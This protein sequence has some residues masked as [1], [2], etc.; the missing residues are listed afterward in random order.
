VDAAV[1]DW[2]FQGDP[3]IR[4][5]V[6]RDLLDAHP[7]E[8]E[9]ERERV[10]TE[11][12]GAQFLALQAPSGRWGSTVYG[13]WTGAFYTM[14]VLRDLGL[15]AGHPGPARAARVILDEGFRPTDGGLWFG[16]GAGHSE[17]C[18][19]GM[20]MAILAL[21][22]EDD[23][24]MQSLYDYLLAEQM[25]DGGWNCQR[26]NGATH[27][28]FHTTI[29][30]L[31]GLL[32]W[33]NRDGDERGKEAAARGTEFLLAHRLFRSHR[34][35]EVV[36][37]DFT[38]FHFPPRW[39]FDVLRGLD[40]MRAAACAPDE[41]AGEAIEL[42]RSRR[43]RDG[44]WQLASGYPGNEAVVMERAGEASRWNTLRALRVLRWWDDG[45]NRDIGAREPLK[46]QVAE[47]GQAVA[48][49]PA[50]R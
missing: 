3:A 48:Q 38:R 50:V 10:A 29:S 7:P 8:F 13:K 23:E 27:S 36:K 47:M 1:R 34:S 9:S 42:V 14:L 11:G 16:T 41:R 31:E 21:Y 43:K 35:G 30:V 46:G 24:R 33:R 45:A 32:E 22:G 18:I 17:S 44:C 12:W 4:W 5:Q 25:P 15:T 19:S 20:G 26:G 2:L 37:A 40:Y 49:R 39:H 6:M 28:S